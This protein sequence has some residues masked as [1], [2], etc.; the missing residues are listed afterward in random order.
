ML[1]FIPRM[2]IRVTVTSLLMLLFSPATA[3][4]VSAQTESRYRNDLAEQSI[5]MEVQKCAH[6]EHLQA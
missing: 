4:V 6:P 1:C 3:A 2:G 5:A